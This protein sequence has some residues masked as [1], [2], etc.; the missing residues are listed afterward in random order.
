MKL[1]KFLEKLDKKQK[2]VIMICAGLLILIIF[3]PTGKNGSDNEPTITPEQNQTSVQTMESYVKYQEKRLKGV[4]EK[5][6]GAGQ[7]YV[8]ITVK[9]S[10]TMIVEKD[11]TT[12]VENVDETDSNGGARKTENK[13]ISEATVY[14]NGTEAPYVVSQTEP[15]IEGV[16]VA[17]S[18]ADNMQVVAEI[19]NA[20]TVLFNVPSHK[21]KVVKME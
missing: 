4:V 5:I 20:V 16:V 8:M 21:I 3:I 6:Q 15:E 10:G 11:R 14:S 1:K 18:G 7:V 17:A 2:L 19:T 13:S 12:N 9:G